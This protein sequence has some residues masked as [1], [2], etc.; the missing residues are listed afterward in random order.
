MNEKELTHIDLF[1]GIGGFTLAGEWAGFKTVVFCEKEPFCQRVLQKRFG[2]VIADPKSTGRSARSSKRQPGGRDPIP[3]I[4]EIRDFD[5]TKWRG[6]TLLTGGFPCQPFSVA[7][8][9]RGKKDDRYLWPEMFRIIKEAKPRWI[10]AENVTGIVKLALGKMLSDL[11]SIGYDFPRDHRGIPIV[12]V[13]P[14]C[15]LN[16]PHRRYRVWVIANARCPYGERTEDKRESERQIHEK[17][18]ASLLERSIENDELRNAPNSTWSRAR[19]EKHRGS[20]QRRQ[21]AKTLE[22]E[23]LRQENRKNCPKGNN[24]DNNYASDS[25]SRMPG[26]QAEQK[27]RKNSGGR[28]IEIV[29][30]SEI[31]EC[32]QSRQTRRGR[33][34]FADR[35]K[36]APNTSQARLQVGE[37]LG[38]NIRQERPPIIR[39]AWQEDWYEVA[40]RF[41][42]VDDGVP[43]RIH[44][45]KALGNAIVPQ[46][47]YEILEN[48][49]W[50]ERNE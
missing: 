29:T 16:A 7:G 39:N 41:C 11:E 13:I 4:P 12:P 15:G 33:K 2:A 45:L 6:A 27:G 10:L 31:P 14:A 1:S 35:D 37:M 19:L 28:N 40:T 42:R 26:E 9:K 43:D 30:D 25:K 32:K 50:I 17:E 22:S 5:G 36:Y 47:A 3:L 24:P 21:S 18:N 48:I 38:Q 49:A 44:R 8:Q 34:R 20:R 23:I 46:V